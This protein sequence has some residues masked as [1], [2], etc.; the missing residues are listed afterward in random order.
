MRD[1]AVV[2]SE[3]ARAREPELA[4]LSAELAGLFRDQMPALPADEQVSA[5]MATSTLANLQAVHDVLVHAIPPAD[6]SLPVAAAAYARRLAQR[7]VPLDLLLRAYRVGEE[8]FVQWWLDGPGV[9]TLDA[10][11]LLATTRLVTGTVAAYID[12][13]CADLAELHHAEQT[14]WRRGADAARTARVRSVL[15]DETTDP[16]AAQAATGLRMGC[17]HTA[18]VLWT[19]PG[20]P[21]AHRALAHAAAALAPA[22]GDAERPLQVAADT[23]TVWAWVSGPAPVHPDPSRVA[24]AAGPGLRVALGE[25]GRGLEGFRASHREAL[26]AR[27]VAEIGGDG[28]VVGFGEVALAALLAED[29]DALRTWV[30]RVLGDLARDDEACARLRATVRE[31]L[32][33]PGGP[34]EAAARLHVH[35]NTVRYRQRRAEELRGVPLHTGALDVAVA[36]EMCRRLGPG[37]LCAP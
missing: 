6:A 26:R 19:R 32:A 30:Q 16:A 1:P 23:H 36:L 15:E 2:V 14:R 37:V 28:P 24:A 29:L 25:P 33:G 22:G 8:R 7:D 10:R 12:R 18:A 20:V 27:A 31:L 34:A 3:L 35:R 5:L 11:T 4:G 13:V 17:W 21:E 9:A